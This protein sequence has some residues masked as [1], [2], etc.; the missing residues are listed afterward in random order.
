MEPDQPKY[1]R[2]SIRLNEYDYSQNGAYFVTLV[3]FQRKCLFGKIADEQMVLSF[4]GKIVREEWFAST[5]IRKEIHLEAGDFIV[6]PNHI[7]GVVQIVGATGQ[8]PLPINHHPRGPVPKSL[9]SFIVGF[10]SS[11]T[12][13]AIAFDETIAGSIWQRNYYEHIIRDEQEWARIRAYIETN[14]ANWERDEENPE[15]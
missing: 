6:M 11:V 9:S 5:T 15:R 1:H 12:K 8:S 13:R 3:T 14:P 10:K 4:I 2:K 7:H